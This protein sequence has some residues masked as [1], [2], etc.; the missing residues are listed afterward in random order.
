MTDPLTAAAIATLAF[1]GAI[2]AGAGKLTEVGINQAKLLWDKIVAKFQGN[3]MAEEAIADAAEQQSTEI[4][5]EEV[6]PL[7]KVAM[8]KDPEFAREIQN[9]AQKINQEVIEGSGDNVNV[10][11]TSRD[12]SKQTVI[13]KAEAQTQHFGDTYE[14]KK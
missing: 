7:L 4:L 1:E 9:I 14:K 5:Q 8:R 12:R 13:G 2:K 11:A 6:V 3:S 10:T